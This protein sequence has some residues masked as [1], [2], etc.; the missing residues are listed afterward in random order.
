MNRALPKQELA[1][2]ERR[3]ADSFIAI[4]RQIDLIAKLKAQGVA[5]GDSER[6]L[7]TFHMEELNLMAR[8]EQAKRQLAP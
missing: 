4:V 3:L 6:L 2:I 7:A 8:R 1:E 5:T